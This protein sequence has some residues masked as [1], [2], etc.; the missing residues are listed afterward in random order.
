M[1]LVFYSHLGIV[2]FRY[3]CQDGLGHI[4]SD[5]PP[6]SIGILLFTDYVKIWPKKVL[7]SACLAEGEGGGHLSERGYLLAWFVHSASWRKHFQMKKCNGNGRVIIANVEQSVAK[8]AN[9]RTTWIFGTTRDLII[10][11]SLSGTSSKSSNISHFQNTHYM[12]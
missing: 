10:M 4:R 7:L 6:T 1:T 12:I 2:R 5:D 9:P 8:V 3:G 11:L